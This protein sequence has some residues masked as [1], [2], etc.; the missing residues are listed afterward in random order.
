MYPIAHVAKWRLGE[1][2]FNYPQ[3]VDH[4]LVM[5]VEVPDVDLVKVLKS[6]SMFGSVNTEPLSTFRPS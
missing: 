3:S 1:H 6:C 2:D 5:L 4:A